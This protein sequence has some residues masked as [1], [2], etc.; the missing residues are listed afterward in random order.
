MA[1]APAAAAK[2]SVKLS[3]NLQRELDALPAEIER[4]EGEVEALENEIGD[5][6][7]YQQEAEAVTAKLQ[8]LEKVQK[9]LEV[10]MERWM[11]LEALAAGE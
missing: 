3:Y 2:K 6:A 7:F 5:P 10:A 1:E 8:T 4:L 11:E 9:S